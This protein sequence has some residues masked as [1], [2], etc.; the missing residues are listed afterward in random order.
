MSKTNKKNYWVVIHDIKITLHVSEVVPFEVKLCRERFVTIFTQEGFTWFL[1]Y[2]GVLFLIYFS[3]QHWY[4]ISWDCK[5]WKFLFTNF[6]L[7][8]IYWWIN[9]IYIKFLLSIC[10]GVYHA[11]LF[12]QPILVHTNPITLIPFT[13]V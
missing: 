7:H 12:Y 2:L 3:Y 5:P 10:I 11:F 6:T 1:E 13:F 9:V 4:Y 8:I